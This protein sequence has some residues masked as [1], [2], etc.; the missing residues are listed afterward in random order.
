MATAAIR[1]GLWW[2]ALAVVAMVVAHGAYLVL[3]GFQA[4]SVEAG[5]PG[6]P[7]KEEVC[8]PFVSYPGLAIVSFLALAGVA[9][10]FRRPWLA[11]APWAIA[12]AT[13]ILFGLSLGMLV[14]HCAAVLVALIVGGSASRRTPAA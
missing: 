12:T 10:A 1:S 14:Y 7:R 5:D 3:F 8:E 2:A 4:C 6:S 13:T 11:W 9:L